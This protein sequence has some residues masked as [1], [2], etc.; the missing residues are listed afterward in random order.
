MIVSH[1]G[2]IRLPAEL[3][4]PSPCSMLCSPA[5]SSMSSPCSML[6]TY[7]ATDTMN[8]EGNP[9]QSS[10]DSIAAKVPGKYHEFSDLFVDKEATELPPHCSHDIKIELEHGKSPPFGPIYSLTDK[11]KEVLWAYLAD[12]L[13]KGFIRPST[14]L[15]ASPILFVK[16]GNGS[17]RLC[18]DYHGLNAITRRNHYPLPLV[19]DLLKSAFNL[20]RVASGDEWKMAFRTNEGLFE[21]LIMPFGLTNAP[22]AFQGFIQ[23]VLWEHLGIFCMVYL[24]DILIFSHSQEEHNGHVRKVLHALR[25]HGLLTSVDECEF[26][27]EALE[28]LGFIIGKEGIV[29]HPKKLEMIKSWP[30]PKSVKEVQSFLGFANF[31]R[32]FISHYS[33]IATPLIEVTKKDNPVPF[34]LTGHA[35]DSFLELKK[36]FTST[37]LLVHHNPSTPIFLFTDASDFAISGI[38]HQKD[39]EGNLHLLAYYS[40][41]LSESEINYSVHDKEMLAIVESLREF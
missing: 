17:L 9:S 21:Y 4:P 2:L 39:T 16:K 13:A 33:K 32:C 24:D 3:C 27:Q 38:P 20:L 36:A 28:Y 1:L 19:N 26:D 40:R 11:E 8:S 5:P 7:A 18:V 37:P 14:S 29:M 12:N 31:Y 6:S 23:W 10:H 41:K 15:A 25:E 34:P 22:A 35:L 30:M